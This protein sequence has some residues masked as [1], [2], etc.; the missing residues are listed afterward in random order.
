MARTNT[1]VDRIRDVLPALANDHRLRLFAAVEPGSRRTHNLV[2]ALRRLGFRVLSYRKAVREWFDLVLA[3][4]CDAG[5]AAFRGPKVVLSHGAGY[6]RILPERT[7]SDVEPVGLSRKELLAPHGQ[8]I[9]HHLGLSHP[10]QGDRLAAACPEVVERSV[11]I[12][13][14]TFD[15][16]LHN[17]PMRDRFRQSLGVGDRKLLLFSTT[18]GE[19]GLDS[20]APETVLRFLAQLPSDE[21]LCAMVLH[22]NTWHE[23]GELG[24][25]LRYLDALD[26]GLR[27]IPG[28]KGWRQALVAS[29]LIVGD[30]GSPSCYA[31]AL[32]IPFLRA[33]GS[34]A[35]VDPRSPNARLFEARLAVDPDGDLLAQVRAASEPETVFAAWQVS[36]DLVDNHGRS[37]L[38][39]RELLYRVLRLAI[40]V[41]R[42]RQR[43]LPDPE[44]LPV[45]EVRAFR[46]ATG[47]A[48]REGC[49]GDLL[50]RRFPAVVAPY[51]YLGRPDDSFLAISDEEVDL[52]FRHSAEVVVREQVLAH[53]AAVA[54]TGDWR[55]FPHAAVLAVA[56]PGGSVVRMRNGWLV[57]TN[58]APQLAAAAVYTWWR[59]R[60]VEPGYRRLRVRQGA[61]RVELELTQLPG[62]P[63]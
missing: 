22:H 12:G 19:H 62:G 44:P 42:L 49:D 20:L 61:V 16:L 48:A 37:L 2:E 39:L 23:H 58:G 27:L 50:V 28:H 8:P 10:E 30:H 45:K 11:L 59:E 7:G 55:Q 6:A 35:E 17:E 25:E 32:K 34:L 47:L 54:W 46:L 1:T 33:A 21:W 40:P 60:R 51:R 56:V 53:G 57:A 4:H 43:P 24:V 13:D 15:A 29:D 63:V 52:A 36:E 9:P 31:A 5:L 3:A 26:A 14:P 18:W 41:S 38:S